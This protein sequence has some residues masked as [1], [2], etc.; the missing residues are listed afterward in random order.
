MARYHAAA[1]LAPRD[2]VARAIDLERPAG[3]RPF[4]P[5]PAWPRARRASPGNQ[6][7]RGRGRAR[8]PPGPGRV[9]PGPPR[10]EARWGPAPPRAP[11]RRAAESPR[12][13]GEAAAARAGSVFPAT[14]GVAR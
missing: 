5:P 4:L 13:R 9:P 1:E 3:R 10:G 12:A 8:G 11:A 6:V 2:V 14:D 7:A